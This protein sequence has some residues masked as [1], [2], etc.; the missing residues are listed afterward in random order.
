[1]AKQ[2]RLSQ[3]ERKAILVDLT[4]CTG[5]RACQVACREMHE[6]RFE[7]RGE[8]KVPML[9]P[10]NDRAEEKDAPFTEL[11]TPG[12]LTPRTLLHMRCHEPYD[13]IPEIEKPDT[14]KMMFQRVS[15]MHCWEAT[16]MY[17]CPVE[18]CITRD[19]KSGGMVVLDP[20]KCVGCMY[21]VTTCP[22][23]VPQFDLK[24]RR[25]YKCNGCYDRVAKGETPL[26]V[27]ACPSG[28]LDFGP[29]IALS[30]RG[31]MEE[32]LEK[33]FNLTKDKK[34]ENTTRYGHGRSDHPLGGLGVMYLL[35][36]GPDSY[37]KLPIRPAMP[38]EV[39]AWGGFWKNLAWILGAATVLFMIVHSVVVGPL[40]VRVVIE[41]EAPPTDEEL[42]KEFIARRRAGKAKMAEQKKGY[43]RK[44]RPVKGKGKV[45]RRRK[46]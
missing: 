30:G 12:G 24:T 11:E 44:R 23:G 2:K 10:W 37:D 28:A 22:F 26:C 3:T 33:R 35:E 32:E 31:G 17:V 25:A 42:E 13:D 29:R 20:A 14:V 18:D 41:D 19:Y 8:K 38:G 45:P 6:D 40:G 43:T 5:C 4:R 21:C 36:N 34:M 9:P 7:T 1:M 39:A 16:C 15:C 27:Q 46:R